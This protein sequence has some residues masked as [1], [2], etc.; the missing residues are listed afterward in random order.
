M[1]I[2]NM[3]S[4]YIS[5]TSIHK[6]YNITLGKKFQLLIINNNNKCFFIKIINLFL[7]QNIGSWGTLFVGFA[8]VIF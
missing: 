6:N 5:Y 7:T 3:M 1:H 4:I 2:L 8:G